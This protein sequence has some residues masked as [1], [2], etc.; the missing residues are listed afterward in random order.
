MGI[1][2]SMSTGDHP[3]PD[4][5]TVRTNRVLEDMLR[6]SGSPN[7]SDWDK[8]LPLVEFAI[9][10]AYQAS[11]KETPFFLNYGQHPHTPAIIYKQPAARLGHRRRLLLTS[12]A[13]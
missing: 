12:Q 10:N 3:Q 5:Q 4:R 9:N 11:V 8:H 1:R 6:H 13:K 2:H 7:Q